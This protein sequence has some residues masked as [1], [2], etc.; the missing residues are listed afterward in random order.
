MTYLVT[1]DVHFSDKPRD[2]Y[3]FGLLPWLAKQAKKYKADKVFILGDLTENKD[4][5]SATLV[6]KVV[7]G[8]VVLSEV[9]DV[10][11]LKGN[12]DFLDPNNPFFG[13]LHYIEGIEYVSEPREV[14]GVWLVPHQPN[15]ASFDAALETECK[16]LML[17]Q[18]VEGAIAETGGHLGGLNVAGI[19]A[20]K[21]VWCLSGDIH[22]PQ[23]CGPVTY[24]GAPYHVRF[25]DD[26]SPRVLLVGEVITEKYFL[27]PRKLSLTVTS[28]N[29]ILG[30][31]GD[32]VKITVVL[33]RQEVPDWAEIKQHALD[34]CR[35]QRLEV[36]GLEM[37]VTPGK[38]RIRLT[39]TTGSHE[40]VFHAFC[41]SEGVSPY[42]KKVGLDFLKE[43]L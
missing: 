38:E 19:A 26:F 20:L 32:Q 40:D 9:T 30:D 1:A 33:N 24:V 39:E 15:Q 12:H 36:Y 10:V 7:E 31:P 16:K 22:R 27:A 2:E 21:P 28:P 14:D 6:K 23:Q 43:E 34:V 25:G 4:R 5:H 18:T 8:L 29:D 17:H 41:A 42:L 11:I 35:E 13:F 37:K 3:R